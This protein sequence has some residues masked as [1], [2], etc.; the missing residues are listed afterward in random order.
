[1]MKPMFEGIKPDK[2]F[3]GGKGEEIFQGMMLDQYGK[4]MAERGG[5]GIADAVKAEL[6]RIQAQQTPAQGAAAQKG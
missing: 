3:G 2:E 1:M 5:L 6:L 4:I